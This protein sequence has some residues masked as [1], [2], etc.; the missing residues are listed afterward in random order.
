MCSIAGRY[1]TFSLLI[2]FEISSRV[3]FSFQ[4]FK[5]APE[6]ADIS[7]VRVANR[8]NDSPATRTGPNHVFAGQNSGKNMN[9][10]CVAMASSNT[11]NLHHQYHH[12]SPQVFH[13][14]KESHFNPVYANLRSKLRPVDIPVYNPTTGGETSLVTRMHV[15]IIEK[16]HT[17]LL[18]FISDPTRK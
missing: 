4:I 6:G 14:P 7:E 1:V 12:A 17:N 8:V 9:N 10:S 15:L 3:Q 16:L 2:Y 18:F 11:T 5:S 13:T